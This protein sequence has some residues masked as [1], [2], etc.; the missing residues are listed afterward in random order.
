MTDPT[1]EYSD[2]PP[3]VQ[4][5]KD[6][7][8]TP[9][10]SLKKNAPRRKTMWILTL[11]F[12]IAGGCWF[13]YWYLYLRPYETTDDAYANGNFISIN[14][15]VN[16]SVIAFFADNTDLVTEGQLLVSFDPTY[17]QA[18]YEKELANLGAIV[19]QVRQLYA[20]VQANQAVVESKKTT[21]SKAQFDYDNRSRLIGSKAISNE[22]FIH[23]KENFLI[24]QLDLKQAE[25]Q[26]QIALDAAG[27]TSIEQHPLIEQQKAVVL[28][29][30]YNLQHCS[31]YA[32]TTGYIA[33]RTVDVG[34]WVTPA[35]K[36][37]ALIPQDYVWVD[38]NFKE[39]Q[40][41]YMRIGQPAKVWF[42][43]YGRDVIYEGKVLGIAS[44]TGSIFSIIPP[45]NATGN[46]IKI[47]QRL[48]V[49]ISL[50][51]KTL[52]DYPIRLGISAEVSVD[53]TDR[54]LPLL[55]TT[56]PSKPVA[57]TNV[58]DIHLEKVKKTIEEVIQKN[59]NPQALKG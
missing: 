32:P 7:S 22:E 59:L 12:L 19:L 50:D 18:I 38:A 5:D 46:W 9:E 26:L 41:T 45:Q 51:P 25:A 27:N 1:N 4:T 29:A 13:A 28:S 21:L 14:S 33:Q 2:P 23:S 36:M 8:P 11:L 44:G 10:P 49:R 20:N 15:A 55:A 35:N 53:I 24:S 31:I 40:L 6:V 52:K 3:S 37:M 43:I 30:Y 47:V 34:H 17:Y 58:F 16:G 48:P 56:P 57:K 39:T 42:D 54:N